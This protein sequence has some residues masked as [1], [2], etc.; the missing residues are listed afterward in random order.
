M[1]TQAFFSLC[2]FHT[3]PFPLFCLSIS[4]LPTLYPLLSIYLCHCLSSLLTFLTDPARLQAQYIYF[5][6]LPPPF[7]SIFSPFP[8]FLP[9]L[10]SSSSHLLLFPFFFIYSPS[11]F[12]NVFLTAPNLCLIP[13]IRLPCSPFSY[14]SHLRIPL[15]SPSHFLSIPILSLS[16]PMSFSLVHS[17]PLPH[18]FSLLSLFSYHFA[19]SPSP[20]LFRPHCLFFIFPLLASIPSVFLLPIPKFPPFIFFPSPLLPP[21]PLLHPFVSRPSSTLSLPSLLPLPLPSA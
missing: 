19:Q 15:Y 6:P 3:V 13:I 14:H 11:L 5:L 7:I 9:T 12:L 17:L 4:C 1:Y 18:F 21:P 2:S 20:F 10:T 8:F 16:L